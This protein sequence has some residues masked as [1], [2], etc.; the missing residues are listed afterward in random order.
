MKFWEPY[1]KE[2]E[3]YKRV[4]VYR[5]FIATHGRLPAK[6]ERRAL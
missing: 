6:R 4:Q 1:L 2:T 3:I 5:E